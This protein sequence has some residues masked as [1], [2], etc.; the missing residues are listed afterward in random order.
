MNKE[1]IHL[2]QTVFLP[3]SEPDMGKIQGI[4]IT[5]HFSEY[6][7]QTKLARGTIDLKISYTLPAYMGEEVASTW[8]SVLQLEW[9]EQIAELAEGCDSCNIGVEDL[10]WQQ[11]EERAV[12]IHLVMVLA[13][14]QPEAMEDTICHI[15][16]EKIKTRPVVSEIAP[17]PLMSEATTPL[18][19]SAKIA[20][21][22]LA[23]EGMRMSTP[24]KTA[25]CQD[26]FDLAG[27]AKSVGT[28]KLCFYRVQNGE[29]LDAVAEKHALSREIIIAAN[30]VGEEDIK[31]G[32]LLTIPGR[33]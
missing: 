4:T 33:T 31:T 28:Y 20:V 18:R 5:P 29:D 24:V 2:A 19:S 17:S 10:D 32:M 26:G 8:Q 1:R 11:L 14:T 13:V 6:N 15:P 27:L 7:A 25:Y 3:K 12:E 23:T 16:V 30:R 21:E 22:R 9:Q